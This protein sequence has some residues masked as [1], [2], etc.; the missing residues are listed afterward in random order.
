VDYGG[1]WRHERE[2]ARDGHG[3][4]VGWKMRRERVRV[5]KMSAEEARCSPLR[6]NSQVRRG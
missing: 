3:E 1:Q 6:P 4:R 5:E 2:L